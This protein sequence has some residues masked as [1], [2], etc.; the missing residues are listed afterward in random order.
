MSTTIIGIHGLNNKPEKTI[1]SQWWKDAI[2]EGLH[3]NCGYDPVEVDFTLA[4]WRDIKHAQPR[5]FDESRKDELYSV[6]KYVPATEGEIMTYD[7]SMIDTIR[8]YGLHASG[9]IMDVFRRYFGKDAGHELLQ[10][11]YPDLHDYYANENDRSEIRNRL[12]EILIRKKGS[13]IILIAHSMGTIIAYDV[14]CQLAAEDDSFSVDH[15]ITMG[16]PLGF[17]LVKYKIHEEFKSITTPESVKVSWLNFSDRRD[18]VCF[19]EH[20]KDD[21]KENS[22]GIQVG[23][24]LVFN[25]YPLPENSPNHH[26]VYGY[27]RTP[28]FSKALMAMLNARISC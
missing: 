15:F 8:R 1:Y 19:D 17:P 3:H 5:H 11:K 23:D 25:D 24:D 4:Y 20:L 18:S 9:S 6:E 13:N 10:E 22:S 28:E 27:L 14:L 2:L 21:F 16:S 26:K 12:R 7:Q